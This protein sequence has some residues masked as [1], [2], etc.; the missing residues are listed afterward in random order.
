V[1]GNVLRG[2][3]LAQQFLGIAADAEV[4]DL[5]DLD[6]ALGVDD[7]RAAQREAF[8]LDQHAEVAADGVGRVADHR[9]LDL[10]DRL[11]RVVPGL[12]GEVSVGRD[13]VDLDAELLELG[14]QVGDVTQ[15]RRADE[16]EV[17]G[18]EE[19]H[20]PLALQVGLRHLDEFAIVEGGGL[21]GLHGRVDDRAHVR[22]SVVGLKRGRILLGEHLA[23]A[24]TVDPID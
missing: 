7:E 13:A 17:G 23:A 14:I 10:A 6:H 12:V 20:R 9:V 16:G 2:L 8:V 4:V 1:R 24:Q 22:D 15:L 19:E 21:E 5:G 11:R 3:H 18:V